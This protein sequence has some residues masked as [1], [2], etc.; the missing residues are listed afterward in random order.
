[1]R[2]PHAVLRAVLDT[3]EP[4]GDWTVDSWRQQ[5]IDAQLTG[6]EVVA[7]HQQAA[8]DGFLRVL[9]QERSIG[10][11]HLSRASQHPASKGRPVQVYERTEK[12]VE[13][14]TVMAGQGALF[15]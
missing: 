8:E 1:M 5:I 10:F 6:S 4:G 11:C 9:G 7:A 3:V 12:R 15:Q 14:V 2:D 13:P